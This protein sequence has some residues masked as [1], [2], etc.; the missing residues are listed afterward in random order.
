M[1]YNLPTKLSFTRI[2]I[3]III[4][5]IA[6]LPFAAMGINIPKFLISNITI[7]LRF[8]IIGVLFVIGS[9]T[10]FLDGRIARKRN[11]VTDFGKMIDSIA[12]KMLVN[13][14]LIILA[15]AGPIPAVI[16][17]IIVLRDI[18]VDAMKMEAASKGDVVAAIKSGKLKTASLMIGTTLMFFYNL[19]FELWGYKVADFFLY[20]GTLMSLYSMYEYFQLNKKYFL[21]QK[22]KSK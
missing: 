16:P 17:I 7:D 6:C 22:S 20:F 8:I 11:M 18:I 19:P 12:D 15:C 5:L 21:P 1:K 3:S 4:I 9:F 14:V 2:F 10:D 13:S